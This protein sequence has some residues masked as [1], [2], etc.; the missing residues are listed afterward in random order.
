MAASSVKEQLMKK[1][2]IK[3]LG[4]YI[5]L[6]LSS[7]IIFVYAAYQ[8]YKVILNRQMESDRLV[9]YKVANQMELHLNETMVFIYGLRGFVH[10]QLDD[11]IT[12]DEFEKFS[13]EAQ[14]YGRYVRNF[15]IAPDNIQQYV[16]PIIGN[17]VTIGHNLT[18]DKRENV[19][20]DVN[21]AMETGNIIV[22]GPYE[23]RQGNLG[24]VLRNPIYNEQTYWGLVNVVVDV[25]S[26][27]A[28][29]INFNPQN[30]I[31]FEL[32]SDD[33]IFYENGFVDTGNISY[34][35]EFAGN[36]WVVNGYI[37][38][39]L[40]TENLR[41]LYRDTL[42]YLLLI[43]LGAFVISRI[44]SNNFLLSHKVKGLIYSDTL[45]KLPNRRALDLQIEE[46]I[47]DEVP[48]ALGFLDL[49]NFKDIN[50]MLGHSFGDQVLI[51]IT[52]RIQDQHNYH[53]YRW[54][55][56]EFIIVKEETDKEA[57][58]QIMK[59]IAEKVYIPIHLDG[60]SYH[61]T[62]SAGI[63]FYPDD[64]F[65]KEEVIKLADATM[66][67]A[68]KH[69][70][71]NILLYSTE[72]GENLKNVHRVE[73][74]LEQ[75]IHNG[76]L[77][78]HYQPK[79]DFDHQGVK[80]VEALVRWQDENG[81]YVPPSFFIPLAEEI[82]LIGRLDEYVLETVAKQI[83]AWAKEGIHIN[84]A[85]NISAKHFTTSLVDYM[86][87]L[88][89]RHNLT[90]NSIE[91]EITE[92]AAVE[93]FDYT[94]ALIDKLNDM[95]IHIALDDFGTG[96]SS[97]NYLSE[98]RFTTL[99]IDRAFISKLNYFTR[100]YTIVK[101]IVEITK[102]FRIKTIAEGVEES[103]QLE[104]LEKLGCDGYQGYYLSKALPADDFKKWLEENNYK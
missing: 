9:F 91:L 79:Y 18:T 62:C 75:A 48:F 52:R 8:D 67:I 57:F 22:S 2:H 26:I 15:S 39:F 56:D 20:N 21:R 12:P 27:I 38:T 101:S 47:R 41:L 64:G 46:N 35:I 37:Q 19:R 76:E 54:G 49:D 11:G 95:D 10:S 98:L 40:R 65:S 94:K 14:F 97:L 5:L 88:L 55:G 31:N 66:Y 73:R 63:S 77:E 99:K 25:E 1:R 81:A 13:K 84:V 103:H 104:I 72:I 87:D 16:F 82:N 3:K 45:T 24:M 51:E 69:G 102:S 86:V 53:V 71:N 68:K 83:K 17:E 96:F 36:H 89:N 44:I 58:A 33:G 6:V 60:E 32:L 23:L 30:H 59:E 90:P 29:S 43:G 74:R 61:I 50:D 42:L 7:L 28:D 92:T 93:D 70:K 78:V 85:V 100:E 4:V 34:K 80:S